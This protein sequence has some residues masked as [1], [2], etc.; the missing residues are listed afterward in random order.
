MTCPLDCACTTNK[1]ECHAVNLNTA[2]YDSTLILEMTFVDSVVDL[3]T[4]LEKYRNLQR[5][6][7]ITSR[8]LH[9]PEMSS[10]IRKV[11]TILC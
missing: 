4:I 2:Y 3:T 5:L 10:V 7:F 6:T 1:M 9:C 8:V 11:N